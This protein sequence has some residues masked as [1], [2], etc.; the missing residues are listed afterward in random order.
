MKNKILTF[1]KNIHFERIIQ[2][3]LGLFL[4]TNVPVGWIKPLQDLGLPKVA[5]DFLLKLWEINLIMPAVKGIEFIA[6]IALIFNRYTFLALLLF[7]PVLFN[8]ACISWH[9]FGSIQYITPMLLGILYLSWIERKNF[10]KLIHS[11]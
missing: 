11:Q 4:L 6:G 2:I 10:S 8:I 9:F 1:T 5:E 7:Y 3:A